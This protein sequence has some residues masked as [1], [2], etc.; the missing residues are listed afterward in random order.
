MIVLEEVRGAVHEEALDPKILQSLRRVLAA[1]RNLLGV[2][3]G[4]L[5]GALREEV[6][7]LSKR[8]ETT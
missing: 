8:E 4:V 7:K 2:L 6:M 1:V 5:Q 3:L